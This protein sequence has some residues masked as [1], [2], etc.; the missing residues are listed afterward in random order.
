MSAA[1]IHKMAKDIV[2]CDC[3][4]VYERTTFKLTVRDID[5][6]ECSCGRTL[7]SWSGSRLPQYK[8]V[9]DAPN[10]SETS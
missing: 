8:K 7:E 6:F 5:S 1:Y 3:G 2:T 9:K 4:T 10:A